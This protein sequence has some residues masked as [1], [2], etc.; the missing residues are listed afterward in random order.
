MFKQEVKVAVIKILYKN[1]VL[2]DLLKKRGKIIGDGDF[3]KLQHIES[4]L[5]QLINENKSELSTPIGAFVS[6]NN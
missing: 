4:E 6:F 2:I 5:N 3:F 1:G